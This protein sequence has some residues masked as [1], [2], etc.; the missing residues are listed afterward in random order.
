MMFLQS[1][2]VCLD[3][4]LKAGDKFDKA[5]YKEFTKTGKNVDYIVWPAL[6]LHKGGPLL[7]K[8]VAEPKK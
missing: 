4:G 5:R 1:P 2:P 7:A 6:L 3:F 8:G